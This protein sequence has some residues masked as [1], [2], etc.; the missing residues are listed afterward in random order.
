MS[1]RPLRTSV[2]ALRL[3]GAIERRKIVVWSL[4]LAGAWGAGSIFLPLKAFVV[5][6]EQTSHGS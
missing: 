3:V 5:V 2:V 4:G 6:N 1:L